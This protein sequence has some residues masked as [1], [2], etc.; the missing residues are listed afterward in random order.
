MTR[1][2]GR[3]RM[4]TLI[5]TVTVAVAV[6]GAVVRRGVKAS[7]TVKVGTVETRAKRASGIAAAQ[8]LP[9]GVPLQTLRVWVHAGAI[10]PYVLH[11][12]PG[13]AQLWIENQTQSE[14]TLAVDRFLPDTATLQ[15]AARVG[16]ADHVVGPTQVIVLA[17][18]SYVFYE[19]SN[20]SIRGIIQVQTH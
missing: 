12:T 7:A 11:A 5:A 20:P 6:V 18:G 15:P 19:Q 9:S 1:F 13:P 8:V 4:L 3:V 2:S 14:V 10:Y 16:T 17:A